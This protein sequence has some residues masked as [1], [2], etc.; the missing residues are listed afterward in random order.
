MVNV[1]KERNKVMIVGLGS[2]GYATLEILSRNPILG[3]SVK[4]IGASLTQD[5][6]Q[7]RVNLAIAIAEKL[8][9]HPDIEFVN[10]NLL[11]VDS[12]AETLRKFDPDLIFQVAALQH[13][14]LLEY[15]PEDERRKLAQAEYG[16]WLP[17]QITLPYNLMQAINKAGINPYVV[18][19]SFPDVVCP[20]LAQIGMAPTVGIGNLAEV[21]P[22]IKMVVSKRLGVPIRDVT[23]RMVGS[24][25]VCEQIEVEGNTAGAPYYLRIFLNGKDITQ[26]IDPEQQLKREGWDDIPQI[27]E[28]PIMYNILTAAT[29]VQAIRAILQDTREIVTTPG[30]NGLPGAYPTRLGR[31][32]IEIVLPD[33]I[34]LEEAIKINGEG[35][36]FDG[37]EEIKEDGTIVIA[38][39]SHEIMRRM[40]GH[41]VKRFNVRDSHMVAGE[42]GRAF[43]SYAEGIGLPDGVLNSIYA[44]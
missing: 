38:D 22:L 11:D 39:K 29:A 36:R 8:G 19:A 27:P 30:P 31:G 7:R 23:V 3:E 25:Y 34:T 5:K 15:L 4:I 17:M 24:H 16:P 14:W 41:D 13:W 33:D 28:D 18:N 42:L 1:M 44:R 43:R 40:L 21:T 26:Q 2:V 32:A 6:G 9:L 37:I 10:L 12:T 35:N 20:A